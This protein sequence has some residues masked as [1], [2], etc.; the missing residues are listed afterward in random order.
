MQEPVVDF[1]QLIT[2]ITKTR[3]FLGETAESMTGEMRDQFDTILGAID[4]K[5]EQFKTEIPKTKSVFEAKVDE[6]SQRHE[7]NLS[8]LEEL[9]SKF[10]EMESQIEKGELPSPQAAPE[11]PVDTQLGSDLRDE[12]L[13][14]FLPTSVDRPPQTGVAWQ[15]W[16]MDGL[17]RSIDTT[18]N[19]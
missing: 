12:L 17:W 5:F 18:T 2:D 1:S 19:Q 13:S 3:S 6:L 15:D 16:D 4:E 11:Q 8:R 14:K 7:K 10:A 9:K